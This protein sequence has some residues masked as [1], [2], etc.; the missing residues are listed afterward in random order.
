MRAVDVAT[1][2]SLELHKQTRQQ[3]QG[4]SFV[5][6]MGSNRNQYYLTSDSRAESSLGMSGTSTASSE[7]TSERKR[8]FCGG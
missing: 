6:T 4:A 3:Q 8:L 1:A 2:V 5:T 7:T